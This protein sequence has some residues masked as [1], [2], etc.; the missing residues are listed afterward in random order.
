M[1]GLERKRGVESSSRSADEA[2]W[3]VGESYWGG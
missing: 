1:G 3:R 2:W